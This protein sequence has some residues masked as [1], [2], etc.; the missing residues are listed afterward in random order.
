MFPEAASEPDNRKPDLKTSD[1]EFSRSFT[2]QASLKL[3]Q[4]VPEGYS[5]TDNSRVL[6]DIIE[7]Y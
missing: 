1:T 4:F 6:S 2:S 7:V 3:S 5:E